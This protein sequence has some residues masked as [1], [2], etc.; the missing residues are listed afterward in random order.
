M[1][2]LPC[3]WRSIFAG[4]AFGFS[5]V[6]NGNGQ[7]ATAPPE[8]LHLYLLLGQSGMAAASGPTLEPTPLDRCYVLGETN[9]WLA[10][11][12][13]A[14]GTAF[15]REILTQDPS[16]AIG[17]IVVA[18]GDEKMEAWLGKSPL[19]WEARKRTK[20]AL[21][22]G[23][24]K[25]VVWYHVANDEPAPETYLENVRS[26]IG[27]LRSDFADSNLPFVAVQPPPAHPLSARIANLPKA[28]HGTSIVTPEGLNFM[29]D[30]SLEAESGSILAARCG[31]E[32]QK[33]EVD[34]AARAPKPPSDLKFIDP[35]VHAMSVKPD[36]LKAVAKWM[37][38][39]NVERCIVSPLSHKGS[40]PQNEEERQTMLANFRPYRG[41]IDRMCIIDPGEV[42][43][44]DDAV[45]ILRREVADGAVAFGEHY[46]VGLMFDDPKNLL[47]YEACQKVGLPVMFHIDQNKNMVEPSMERVDRVLRMF[48]KCKVV[49]HAY[50]WRQLQ[51]GTCDRQLR[52]HPN[53]YADM[54]GSVV[55]N[56]LNRDRKY[57][58]EFILRHQDKLLWATDEGWW[59][60]GD[61]KK[62]MNQH[63]TFFEE[64]DLPDDVRRKIYRDNALKVYGLK[65]P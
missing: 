5:A 25:G 15:A 48:P 30:G 38:D 57:A 59:S 56:V 33:L 10:A 6:C 32:M 14:P 51:N 29:P 20:V 13:D 8:N 35:H 58:R 54:S 11:N 26:I 63:Y 28:T 40:R 31:A 7:L 24:L 23:T 41:K 62:Q 1:S 4:L 39:R 37:E 49:A 21:A 12:T 27:N 52:E 9:E 17:L 2:H 19:Y 22:K 3:S 53:L 36:G 18:R 47:L 34:A 43:T 45:S 16:R 61:R 44:V 65:N 42:Q 60:F 46:G 55:V 64:L 50:W